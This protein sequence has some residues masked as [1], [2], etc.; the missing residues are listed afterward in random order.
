VTLRPAEADS[1]IRFRR[2]D[3]TNG[4]RSTVVSAGRRN[5]HSTQLCTELRNEDGV[6]VMTVEHLLAALAGAG[7]DNV[8]VHI[9]GPEVPILDGSSREFLAAIDEAGIVE[10][11][12]ERGF[13]RVLEPVSLNIGQSS[14]VFEPADRPFIET[15]IDFPHAA[16]GRQDVSFEVT[17]EQFRRDIASARTF[18]FLVQAEQLRAM[19]FGLGASLD[20]TIVLDETGILNA[21]GLRFEDEFVRHKALDA[22]GDLV[23]AGAPILGRYSSVRGGH[24]LNHAALNCLMNQPNAWE[25]VYASELETATIAP[26]PVFGAEVVMEIAP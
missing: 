26:E 14:A 9:S 2:V 7:V 21:E 18:G 10:Q 13:I 23:I 16:I 8:D 20:N 22:C 19:G 5:V 25:Y 4:T 12:F 1:G 3:L 6:S 24:Q 17:P 15:T 11:D